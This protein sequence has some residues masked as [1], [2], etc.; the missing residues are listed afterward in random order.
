[1][2]SSLD[3]QIAQTK[4]DLQLRKIAVKVRSQSVVSTAH[5][6]LASPT[7]LW[8]AAG[9]GFFIGK[10]TDR[11]KKEKAPGKSKSP[12]NIIVKVLRVIAGA[13]TA[14]SFAKHL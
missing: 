4:K 8:V 3:D 14:S 10:M 9:T 1:M 2:A 6:K 7:A 5:D 11:P 13:Q 12:T